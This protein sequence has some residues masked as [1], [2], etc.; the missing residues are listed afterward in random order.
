MY[1]PSLHLLVL[2]IS[3]KFG[4]HREEVKAQQGKVDMP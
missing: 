1:K 4:E 2:L 3:L